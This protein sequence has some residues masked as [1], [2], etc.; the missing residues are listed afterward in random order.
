MRNIQE[1]LKISS[2]EINNLKQNYIKK[3]D[4]RDFKEFGDRFC[5]VHNF[6]VKRI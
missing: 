1:M 2:D 3:L 6:S 5:A 4:N